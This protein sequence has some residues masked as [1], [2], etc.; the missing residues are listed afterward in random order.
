MEDTHA[1]DA[2]NR[3]LTVVVP[4]K[5]EAR[6]LSA[7]LE[8]VRALEHLVV[9]DSNSTDGTLAVATRFGREVMQFAWNG[10]F[11]KKRNWILRNYPFKTPW[12]MFL[13]A[14][15][16]MTQP[17]WEELASFLAS[18]TADKCDV[19]VCTYDNWFAER[20]LKHGD[21]MRKTAV[22]RVGAAEYERIDEARWSSFDMEIHEHIQAKR[23]DAEHEIRARLEHHD[24][25]SLERHWQKHVEYANWEANRYRQLVANPEHWAALTP[26]QK[27]KYGHVT[28]WWLAPVYFAVCYFAKLGFLDGLAGLRFAWFKF[29]YFRL[30]REKILEGTTHQTKG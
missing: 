4:V 27:V 16:R 6:N 20:M 29:R 14:D 11:P 26:R 3:L 1:I 8:S 15:E 19:I 28:R 21:P 10:Q 13:D 5:N 23:A 24:M 9:A 7:C 25:R 18:E 30:V 17:F 22:V 2:L 12:V